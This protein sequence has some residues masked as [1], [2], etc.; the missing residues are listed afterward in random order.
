MMRAY[1][2]Q[3]D[4]IL[5]EAGGLELEIDTGKLGVREGNVL[6]KGEA[7]G[8]AH[9]LVGENVRIVEDGDGTLWASAP[10]GARVEHE[11]HAPIEL[12]AGTYRVRKV[13]VYDHFEAR[14]R[15]VAD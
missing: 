1:Y 15:D 11:E 7:S 2:Q 5:E 8:H 4:V 6:F 3:G 9:V 10:E 12:P 13:Q 14:A